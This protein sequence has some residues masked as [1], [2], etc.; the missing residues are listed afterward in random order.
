MKR[1]RKLHQ[2]VKSANAE[3]DP[4][5]LFG[6]LWKERGKKRKKRKAQKSARKKNR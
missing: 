4:D 5:I 1:S 3:Q 6:Y 2:L